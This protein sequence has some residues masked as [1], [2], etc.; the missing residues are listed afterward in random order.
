MMRSFTAAGLSAVLVNAGAFAHPGEDTH[1][2]T[3]GDMALA[4]A[5]GVAFVLVAAAGWLCVSRLIRP[6]LARTSRKTQN[7]G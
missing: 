2:H 5:S 7:R 3:L 4:A 6:K 1:A